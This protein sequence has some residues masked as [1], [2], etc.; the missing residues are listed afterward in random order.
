MNYTSKISNTKYTDP[1][2]AN[3]EIS[4]YNND[5]INL[6]SDRFLSNSY[7]INTKSYTNIIDAYNHFVSNI[8]EYKKRLI[9]EYLNNLHPQCMSLNL[10]LFFLLTKILVKNSPI[11]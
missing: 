7:N 2:T 8:Y 11:Q 9:N 4:L 3:G 1:F 6:N 10:N 5:R